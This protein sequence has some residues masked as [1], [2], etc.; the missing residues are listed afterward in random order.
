MKI[1]QKVAHLIFPRESNNQRAKLIH[2]S[3]LTVFVFILII[4]QIILNFLPRINPEI[5]GFAAS[6]PPSEVIRLTNEKR[7]QTGL[8]PLTE[9]S[10]LSQAA[11]AKGTDM[12]NRDYW[13][14]VS[15][16]GVQPWK[17][18]TDAGYRYRFAG[19]NLARD[20]SNPSSAVEAWMA[21]ATHKDNI[22]SPKYKEVGIAV[23]EG[24]LAGVDTTIIV[25]FFGTKYV[26]S[27]PAV[28]I[29]EAKSAATTKPT[30]TASPQK[31]A[32]DESQTTPTFSPASLMASNEESPPTGVKP[33][34]TIS[35]FSTTKSVS[36]MIVTVLL[37]VLVVDGVQVSKKK[38]ARVG[39]RSFAHIAFLGMI[40]TIALILRAGQII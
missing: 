1:A 36:L 15:P 30:P 5:L 40:L 21:S 13:S 10:T 34:F 23:I 35:P 3:S 8:A 39:G 29:A 28:P 38:I 19:E 26:D 4:Y 22:L 6:I 11:M 9:N 2:S 7:V 14:H 24:D 32:E 18:F 16:D 27:T 37:I 12:I 25:Q 17:F 33:K 31:I 20:F